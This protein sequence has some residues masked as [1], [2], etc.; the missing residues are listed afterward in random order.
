M[1][2][3]EFEFAHGM[4]EH[5]IDI[6]NRIAQDIGEFSAK[7][8][9]FCSLFSDRFTACYRE[10]QKISE[11]QISEAVQTA[12][13]NTSRM[14]IGTGVATYLINK[15]SDV[16]HVSSS[17]SKGVLTPI[18][19][20]TA[21][22]YSYFQ[23]KKIKHIS[24]G[25][26][27]ARLFMDFFR[28]IDI[29]DFASRLA[30]TIYYTCHLHVELMRNNE[31]GIGKFVNFTIDLIARGV[32]EEVNRQDLDEEGVL[33]K[34]FSYF[35]HVPKC[36][37]D[38]KVATDYEDLDWGLEAIMLRSP[39]IYFNNNNFELWEY[40]GNENYSRR[41]KYPVRIFLHY[42]LLAEMSDFRHQATFEYS[43]ESP[44]S[45]ACDI[46]EL[47]G[48]SE[49]Y[50]SGI[51]DLYAR[52]SSCLSSTVRALGTHKKIFSNY[53]AFVQN[54]GFHNNVSLSRIQAIN[55]YC[56]SSLLVEKLPDKYK[57]PLTLLEQQVYRR[58]PRFQ[59]E[60]DEDV[61]SVSSSV[62]LVSSS[63]ENSVSEDSCFF[64]EDEPIEESKS[65]EDSL[66]FFNDSE[67]LNS[68][69]SAHVSRS[70][71]SSETRNPAIISENR[72]SF[73]GRVRS[74]SEFQSDTL[75]GGV[76]TPSEFQSDAFDW[77]QMI[78]KT[79][80]SITGLDIELKRHEEGKKALEARH[81]LMSN[82]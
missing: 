41:A 7:K 62:S 66:G 43:N 67:D 71:N 55:L 63:F 13:V 10:F 78:Y 19:V 60:T 25:K 75:Q 82:G 50:Y 68:I 40:C 45:E 69:E 27:V 58:I 3:R 33:R 74:T 53:T 73:Q 72:F 16:T 48:V 81:R 28:H 47:N 23:F 61:Q 9:Y 44:I 51:S 46:G 65:S 21:V 26:E 1:Q 70:N 20:G 8:V 15:L 11:S 37:R 14:V 32:L 29:D 76:R 18:A 49:D 77:G 36:W 54:V 56:F 35:N 52:V 24:Q 17:V 59:M 2:N 12:F 34:V 42:P 64:E 31:E 79:F 6:G 80:L 22:A 38:E 5:N 39:V 4:H 57:E 30:D